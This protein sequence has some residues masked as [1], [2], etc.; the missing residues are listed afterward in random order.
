M[1]GFSLYAV[2]DQADTNPELCLVSHGAEGPT[3]PLYAQI[4]DELMEFLEG[5]Q[6]R[7]RLHGRPD[8]PKGVIVDFGLQAYQE[9]V[10]LAEVA[11]T[12]SPT[13]EL[14]DS[15]M[16]LLKRCQAPILPQR[17]KRSPK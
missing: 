3:R 11:G 12:S 6:R 13:P 16:D 2:A 8:V 9:L 7:R 14:V 1:R 10:A 15:L 17:L 4:H 5:E